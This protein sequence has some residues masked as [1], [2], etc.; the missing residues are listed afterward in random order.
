[1]E[2]KELKW[3]WSDSVRL[4]MVEKSELYDS[5]RI[6]QYGYYDGYQKGINDTKASEYHEELLETITDL[7]ILKNQIYLESKV[8]PSWEGMPELI[9]KWIDRK[10]DLIKQATES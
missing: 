7:K 3:K 4:E 8:R 5:P 10:E 2:N 6:Y 9:Q 1:M